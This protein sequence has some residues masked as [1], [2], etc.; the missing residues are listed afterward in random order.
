MI[1]FCKTLLKVTAAPFFALGYFTGCICVWLYGGW[2][3]A[4]QKGAE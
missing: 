2:F 1:D 4:T 3:M